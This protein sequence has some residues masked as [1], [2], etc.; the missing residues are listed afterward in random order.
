VIAKF[1]NGEAPPIARNIPVYIHNCNFRIWIRPATYL[2]SVFP[3]FRVAQ[4]LGLSNQL[5]GTILY[6]YPWLSNPDA[7]VNV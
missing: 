3:L 6:Q 5:P 7:K 4:K 1:S 2:S